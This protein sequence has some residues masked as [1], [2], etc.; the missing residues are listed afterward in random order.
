MSTIHPWEE[1]LCLEW[2][3]GCRDALQACGKAATVYYGY[4]EVNGTP[5]FSH[6]VVYVPEDRTSY[7]WR[8]AGA[9]E[10][11]EAAAG[12]ELRWLHEPLRPLRALDAGRVGEARQM[13]QRLS[14]CA[15]AHL[16]EATQNISP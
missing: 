15:P 13:A 6:A 5:Q 14:C 11:W 9:E 16:E 2:A 3:A 8:G 7:D 1:G 10:R 12:G 4:E